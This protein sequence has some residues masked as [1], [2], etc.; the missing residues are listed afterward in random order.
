MGDSRNDPITDGG[1][2]NGTSM[3][4]YKGWRILSVASDGTATLVHGSATED[5]GNINSASTAIRVL[6]NR[7]WSM[8][9]NEF[10]MSAHCM[11]YSEA[12]SISSSNTLRACYPP[13]YVPQAERTNS[14][15]LILPNGRV[16]GSPYVQSIRPVIQLKTSVG[17]TNGTGTQSNP[18]T[19]AM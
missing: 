5:F 1:N 18:Y 6:Q 3:A 2:F 15:V 19:L 16:S 14:L 7:D 9:V 11:T 12:M 17:Y 4:A 8:Y 10:A 13:Y